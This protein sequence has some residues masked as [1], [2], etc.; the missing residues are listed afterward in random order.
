MR[1]L[2]PQGT[3]RL[4]DSKDGDTE[5]QGVGVKCKKVAQNPAKVE[6]VRNKDVDKNEGTECRAGPHRYSRATSTKGD[7][8][9]G[10]NK[11]EGKREKADCREQ[12]GRLQGE[13]KRA[14]AKARRAAIGPGATAEL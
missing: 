1:E 14:E 9:G 2:T 12:G 4:R 8:E 6:A 5:A 11:F 10:A 13:R 3:E 7:N